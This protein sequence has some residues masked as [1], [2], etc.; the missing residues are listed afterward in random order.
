MPTVMPAGNQTKNNIPDGALADD[1]IVLTPSG[2]LIKV[3]HFARCA[4]GG[5]NMR[6][7]RN[8]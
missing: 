4:A 6:E 5:R 2:F 1:A 3:P 7:W 8:W